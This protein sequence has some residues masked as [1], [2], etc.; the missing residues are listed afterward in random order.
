MF[1]PAGTYSVRFVQLFILF[2]ISVTVRCFLESCP[3][4]ERDSLDHTLSS[5]CAT[6]VPLKIQMRLKM[7]G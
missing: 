6:H 4:G 1:E 7:R 5:C 3:F 2:A